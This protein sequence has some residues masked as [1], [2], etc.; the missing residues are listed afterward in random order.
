M[1]APSPAAGALLVV[2]LAGCSGLRSAAPQTVTYVLRAPVAGAASTAPAGPLAARSLKVMGVVAQPGYDGDRILL[3]GGDRSLGF[4]AASRWVETL[5]E[6]VGT[7]TVETLR[8]AAALRTVL[9]ESAPFGS[10]FTLRLTIRRF[11]AE[12]P[13]AGAPP[14]ITVSFACTVARADRTILANFVVDAQA[15]AAADRMSAVVAAF[16]QATQRALAESVGRTLETLVAAEAT[17]VPGTAPPAPG[18]SP[19]TAPGA[20]RS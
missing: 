19:A 12:Y 8:N 2:V 17:P 1:K 6:V 3:L 15:E 13:V 5:P 11:D 4:F 20:S 16:E 18:G 9:D 7:L 10:D 14:R